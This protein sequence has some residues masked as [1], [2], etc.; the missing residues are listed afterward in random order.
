[1]IFLIAILYHAA[2][3]DWQDTEDTRYC[4]GGLPEVPFAIGAQILKNVDTGSFFAFFN[5]DV[6]YSTSLLEFKPLTAISSMDYNP[7]SKRNFSLSWLSCSLILIILSMRRAC[8]A[9][10][11]AEQALILAMYR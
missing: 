6:M 5:K 10:C 8:I 4:M 9:T 1:M 11:C 2:M 3:K 7:F